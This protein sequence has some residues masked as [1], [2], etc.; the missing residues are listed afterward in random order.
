MVTSEYQKRNQT[1]ILTATF[2][3]LK[4]DLWAWR[5][6]ASL[7]KHWKEKSPA[8]TARELE[9]SGGRLAVLEAVRNGEFQEECGVWT[10]AFWGGVKD[11]GTLRSRPLVKNFWGWRANLTLLREFEK[12]MEEATD[13]KI[14]LSPGTD[15]HGRREIRSWSILFPE[16]VVSSP[17]WLAGVLS[18]MALVRRLGVW[19]L[20]SRAVTRRCLEWLEEAG[21][22]HCGAIGGGIWVSPFYL[23][24]VARYSPRR[25]GARWE[26]LGRHRGREILAGE[27]LP[28][29]SWEVAFGSEIGGHWPDRAWGLPWAVSH[30]QRALMGIDRRR[31]HLMA[32][33]RG[34]S[35]P[36][37][38]LKG[39]CKEWRETR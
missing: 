10:G 18:G 28:L 23:P 15:C 25:S 19:V 32:V 30:G 39:L 26:P 13:V 38:W 11:S 24:L 33:E 6:E 3:A 22:W 12:D 34:C 2:S 16:P 17:Q 20:E 7:K 5:H 4:D 37:V 8:P 14:R 9:T 31:A 29:S 35:E 1:R 21:V 27:W 36:S